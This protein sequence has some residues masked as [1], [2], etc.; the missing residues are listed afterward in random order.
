MNW[1]YPST[2]WGLLFVPLVIAAAFLAGNAARTHLKGLG[3]NRLEWQVRAFLR[4]ISITAFVILA[5]LAAAEPRGGRTPVTGERS[6]LDIAVAFDVSRS[7][8]A[9][10]LEPNRLLRATAALRQ[11]TGTIGDARFSLIPFK[12]NARL[13]VPMTEDRVIIEMWLDRL[14][15]GLSTSPG[16][17]V[18]DALRTALDSFPKGTG[19]KRILILISD[20]ESLEGQASRMIRELQDEGIPVYVLSAGTSGGGTIPLSDGTLVKDETGR[21]VVSRADADALMK[22][23]DD[24][25]GS[26]H[27]L[28]RPGAISELIASVNEARVFAETRGIRFVGVHRYRIYLIPALILMFMYL[29]ARIVPWRR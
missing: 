13:M 9:E 1:S 28:S 16:T 18:E 3:G 4:N 24:T 14:G 10:D 12:G 25:G 5:V 26:Y 27:D 8:L 23:A 15:P 19:R 20:G 17:D 21:P 6:G 29:F 22:I 2:L 7:M 11:I